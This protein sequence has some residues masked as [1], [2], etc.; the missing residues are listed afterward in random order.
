MQ[1]TIKRVLQL[2]QK[3]QHT[4]IKHQILIAHFKFQLKNQ[5]S[6][7]KLQNATPQENKTFNHN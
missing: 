5:E 6:E 7:I 1:S 4:T 2:P 3:K